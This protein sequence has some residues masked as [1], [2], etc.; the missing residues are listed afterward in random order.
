LIVSIKLQNEE[1]YDDSYSGNIRGIDS[2]NL[3]WMGIMAGM[4]ENVSA[5]ILCGKETIW[6][7]QAR[8]GEQC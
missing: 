1:T 4:G 6:K 2:R 3:R 5:Y 7:T 8:M